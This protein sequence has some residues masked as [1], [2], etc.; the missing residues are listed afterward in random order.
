MNEITIDNDFCFFK[1]P[2]CEQ[3]IIVCIKELNCR[4]F[5]HGTYKHNYQQVDPHMNKQYC[6]MLIAENKVF[7][8][9]KPFEIIEKNGKKYSIKCEYK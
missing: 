4:I 9:C 3:E 2:H 1:C 8:C 7:G 6:D 5:R